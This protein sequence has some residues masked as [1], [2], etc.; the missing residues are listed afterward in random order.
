[1]R[2]PLTLTVDDFVNFHI[3]GLTP[4][5]IGKIQK[6]TSLPVKGAFTSAAF[7]AKIWDGRESL[8]TDEGIGVLYELNKVLGH[9]ESCGYDLDE[10]LELVFEQP[11]INLDVPFVDENYLLEYSGYK[12]RDYQMNGINAAIQHRKGILDIATNGGKSWMCV[13]ISR[14]FD[15]VLK[16]VIIVPSEFLVNQTYADYSK[17]DLN[18]IALTADI[19]PAKREAAIRGARHVITTAKLFMNC[20]EFFKEDAWAFVYDEAHIFGDVMADI[21]RMEMGHCPVRI[22]LSA[23]IPKHKADPYKRNKILSYIGGDILTCVAQKELM[24]RGISA[25]L[26]IVMHSTVHQE[27]DELSTEKE[28]DWSVE[29]SYLLQNRDRIKAIADFIQTFDVK[30]TLILCHAALGTQ[31]AEHLGCNMITED[32]PN[33]IRQE[34]FAEFK[35][36]DDVLLAATFGC[37]GTGI[38]VNRVFRQFLID[39]GKDETAILQGIGRGVRLD[40]VLNKIEVVDISARTK[41]SLR[42]RAERIKIYKREGFEFVE[43][44]QFIMV[45]GD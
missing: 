25:K 28:F 6:A 9:V 42:H 5:E 45:S 18:V 3:E 40:G 11:D 34:W 21:L 7:K 41:F 30:N 37:A 43:E 13:G 17:T 19:K 15:K 4:Q 36:N 35:N 1:M 2:K 14:V 24:E 38:S 29:Q 10:D 33:K 32:T 31:L 39:V 27:I 8:L 44:K 20:V 22:G 23:T 26:N 16:S 12:L